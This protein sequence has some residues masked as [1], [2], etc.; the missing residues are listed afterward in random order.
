M[1][2]PRVHHVI[3]SATKPDDYI[4]VQ[5]PHLPEGKCRAIRIVKCPYGPLVQW[6]ERVDQECTFCGGRGE[7][8]VR[9]KNGDYREVDCPECDGGGT[10]WS[11]S[12]NLSWSDADGNVVEPVMVMHD[13]SSHTISENWIKEWVASRQ[14]G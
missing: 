12:G 10:E 7:L 11:Y 3:R 4:L 1:T 8:E 13:E 2:T 14:A 5:P 6:A 9:G